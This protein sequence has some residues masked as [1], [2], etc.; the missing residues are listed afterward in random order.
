MLDENHV[1]EYVELARKGATMDELSQHF[2][3]YR[4]GIY[5]FIHN[6]GL[7]TPKKLHTQ[8]LRDNPRPI[9]QDRDNGM[10]IEALAEK[11]KTSLRVIQQI[12]AKPA[13]KPTLNPQ[14]ALRIIALFDGGTEVSDI[15]EMLQQTPHTVRKTIQK[16]YR[17][18]VPKAKRLRSVQLSERDQKIMQMRKAGH[19][20][21][22]IG[23]EL[24][25][26]RQRISML[27]LD[28]TR[29]GLISAS[30]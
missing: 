9:R 28:L 7:D 3:Y 18:S 4:F 26:T 22:S 24:G 5:Q 11:Y 25:V 15:A 30:D 23:D 14:T 2:G 29:R 12:T 6:Y 20:L 19:T 8:W 17:T 13:Q 21:Q 16:H 27:I 10:S 1:E